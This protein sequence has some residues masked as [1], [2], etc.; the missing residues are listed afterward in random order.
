[1]YIKRDA[2]KTIAPFKKI[3]LEQKKKPLSPTQSPHLLTPIKKIKQYQASRC[4]AMVFKIP[5]L[6]LNLT[7]SQFTNNVFIK[8]D[9]VHCILCTVAFV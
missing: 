3:W 8:F 4:L 7:L 6:C 5:K 9:A 1:M 2:I